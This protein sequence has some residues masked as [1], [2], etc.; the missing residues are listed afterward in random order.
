MPSSEPTTKPS[1][2]P[3]SS[4]TSSP[5]YSPSGTPSLSNAP[6]ECVIGNLEVSEQTDDVF[7][8]VVSISSV[9]NAVGSNGKVFSYF[10]DGSLR[11]ELINPGSSSTF[12]LVLD[13]SDSFIVV[14]G[15]DVDEAYVFTPDGILADTLSSSTTGIGFGFAVAISSSSLA[16]GAPTG[17]GVVFLYDTADLSSSPLEIPNPGGISGFGST[18]A[19]TEDFI[20]VG[21]DL[22]ENVST[23]STSD[24]TLLIVLEGDVD[25]VNFGASL[26]AFNI[27]IFIGDSG[28]GSNP[29]KVWVYRNDNP[30]AI[31]TVVSPNPAAGDNFGISISGGFPLF[32]VG[33]NN[34][35]TAA[36]V[37]YL[38]DAS[39]GGS[40]AASFA[41]ITPSSDD[42]FGSSVSLSGNSRLAVGK[43]GDNAFYLRKLC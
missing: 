43:P 31:F 3:T 10:G 41:S 16:I 30:T 34:D 36:G 19:I 25:N 6:S 20:T 12:G 33:Q 28:D 13:A 2:T 37:V 32:V 29:G 22:N 24:G 8:S 18:L 7:G 1:S 38:F 40:F 17:G 42:G 14:G 5:S 23:F 35:G 26:S 21:G 27:G 9:T 39:S 11:A 15:S 4:P